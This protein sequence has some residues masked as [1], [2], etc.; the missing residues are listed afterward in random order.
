MLRR[1]WRYIRA[2]SYV[3]CDNCSKMFEIDTSDVTPKNFCSNKCLLMYNSGVTIRW[4][5]T[6]AFSLPN[7]DTSSFHSSYLPP[8]SVVIDIP[9][10]I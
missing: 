5:M 10:D 3:K 4:L 1:F 7:G 9:P 6:K 8:V 2:K